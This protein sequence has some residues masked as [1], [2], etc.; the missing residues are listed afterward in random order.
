ML[1]E[2]F[3]AGKNIQEE[4]ITCS[5]TYKNE[6]FWGTTSSVWVECSSWGVCGNYGSF[7]TRGWIGAAAASATADAPKL[8]LRPMP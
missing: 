2:V 3:Q 5:K 4:G 6:H 7:Q 1:D 8:H